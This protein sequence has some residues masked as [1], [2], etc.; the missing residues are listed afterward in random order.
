MK[1]SRSWFVAVLLSCVCLLLLYNVIVPKY[2]VQSSPEKPSF[3][4]NQILIIHRATTHG[5]YC[6][7]ENICKNNTDGN[8]YTYIRH[9][10]F[11]KLIEKGI[12]LKRNITH[13]REVVPHIVHYAW[14]GGLKRG[15][16]FRFHHMLAILSAH[17]FIKP[18]RIYFWHDMVP[19][20]DYW[21][22]V[23]EKV[24]EL[25]LVFRKGPTEIRGRKVVVAEH[26]TDVVRLE[27]VMEFGGMYFDLDVMILK[28]LDPLLKFDVAMGYETPGG[29]CNGIMIGTAWADFFKIWHKE[30]KSF[31]DHQW[32]VHSVQI[33]GR[34]A[35]QYPNLVHTEDTSLHRPNWMELDRLYT[36]GK[37]Y[38]WRKN[39]Y[40][41]H[42]WIRLHKVEHNP[43]DIK[44][45][46]TTVGEMFRWIYY[47]DWKLQLPGQHVN[48][49][50]PP[51]TVSR[52]SCILNNICRT[53]DSSKVYTYQRQA[54]FLQNIDSPVDRKRKINHQVRVIPNIVHFT[55]YGGQTKGN[56]F[57]FHH[58][59][60][61]L[62]AHKFI[63][64][65]HILFW[66]DMVPNGN[67]WK[68]LLQKVPEVVLVYR[69]APSEIRGRKVAVPEHLTDVVR[70][71][72]VL[73]Y[74]GM[75]FD[76]D[77]IVLKPLDA[78]LKYDVV[79]GY[80]APDGL[81]NGII[82][83][84]P[85]ADFLKI[86][87][88]E[89]K[90]FDDSNWNYHSVV[91]PAH[92]AKA[93]PNL[94]H[95]EATSMHRPNYIERDVLYTEG[96]LFKWRVDNFA[97]HLWIRF[98]K[99][100]HNPED[101]KYWNTT[102]GEIFRYIYY[103]DWKLTPLPTKGKICIYGN[104]CKD[105][106]SEKVYK[107][108]RLPDFLS[109]V[110]SDVDLKLNI[111][112][113]YRIVPSISHFTWYGGK[114]KGNTFRFHHLLS[115][116]AAHKFLKPDKVL[117]WHDM[118]PE[119]PYWTEL[120]DKVPEL[121]LV[122]RETPT[123]IRGRKVTVAEHLTDV[124]RLEA[125]M[126]YGGFYFDLDAMVLKPLG[127]LL[128]Y[129][130]TMGYETPDGLCNGIMIGRAWA[131]FF[132]IWHKEY[133][134]FDDRNWAYHSVKLP[135]ILARR[136]P[137]L[138]HT[139]AT[140]MH[141]PNWGELPQLYKEGQLYDWRAK[142]Y[143]VHLWIRFHRPEHNATDIKSWNTTTGEIFRHIYYG[144]WRIQK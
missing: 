5:R 111:S 67:Y 54:D 51:S 47:G 38:D 74:G 79:M 115:I 14:Y 97:V 87:H 10:N 59:I 35:K 39:N 31:Q 114:A 106:T 58:L 133:K 46:N 121:T 33:P 37:L 102:V 18:S 19:T 130:V 139:E 42:L 22:E 125:I 40:A 90:T 6:I 95:T 93:H 82:I 112:H 117:F 134:T 45:W 99:T 137:N 80:E 123:E 43:N 12:D 16:N 21:K 72:A 26:V 110:E 86:W 57:R 20:G 144:D 41:S 52:K 75:Y 8:V 53:N 120:K 24:P 132:R 25:C 36:V 136:F 44:T 105:K 96:K 68:E 83:G 84:K 108:I 116:L 13:Q 30:Y 124:V 119:G 64:P 118:V 91:L 127:P 89:Y 101:I 138:I 32:N 129:D 27:A 73:E 100:E 92:L 131:D 76:L 34:L 1:H 62:A 113:N 141:R 78:L 126:E 11:Y 88:R 66:H 85:W 142:N 135:A 3:P 94:I 70:L 7:E 29:L 17:K 140:S 107:Y 77:A 60:A 23:K 69:G 4:G 55:W 81:C 63:K 71:E 2:L 65:D 104:L 61:V 103:G 98:H 28:P 56:E 49:T 143:A 128:N 122:Y 50:R 48:R 15:N 109:R 9:A